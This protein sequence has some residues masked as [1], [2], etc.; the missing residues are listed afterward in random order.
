MIDPGLQQYDC[1]VGPLLCPAFFWSDTFTNSFLLSFTIACVSYFVQQC[2]VLLA[3]SPWLIRCFY[4]ISMGFPSQWTILR[5]FYG[6]SMIFVWDFRRVPMELQWNSCRISIGFPLGSF[7]ISI[8]FPWESCAIS[9]IFLLDFYE[10]S[11]EF[12]WD[13]NRVSMVFP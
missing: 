4:G 13:L 8:G 2:S 3:S 5:N 10:I 6:V 7:V 12:L 11:A 9:M 1:C